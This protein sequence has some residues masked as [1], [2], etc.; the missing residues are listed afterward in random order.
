MKIDAF[1]WCVFFCWSRCCCVHNEHR[2]TIKFTVNILYKIERTT[3]CAY[4]T[5]TITM[6]M[7]SISPSLSSSIRFF[8]L[9]LFAVLIGHI[10]KQVH[11]IPHNCQYIVAFQLILMFVL[12]NF[13]YFY[14]LAHCVCNACCNDGKKI[15]YDSSICV[16]L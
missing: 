7:G 2:H 5:S 6:K 16:R 3:E 11:I 4:C 1:D 14:S 13:V 8:S 12:C 9:S 15:D 10:H